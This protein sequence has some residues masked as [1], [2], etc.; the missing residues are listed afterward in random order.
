MVLII[1]VAGG[2]SSGK[3][4]FCERIKQELIGKKVIIVSQDDY[5]KEER[6][7]KPDSID[8]ELL[9]SVIKRLKGGDAVRIKGEQVSKPDVV[10]VEGIFTLKNIVTELFDLKIFLETDCETRMIRRM[11]REVMENKRET[12]QVLMEYE[13]FVKPAFEEWILPTRKFANIVIP[14]QDKNDTALKV[15]LAFIN[16]N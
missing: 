9:Y 6:D 2:S 4:T 1:G 5:Y 13:K 12:R 15:V 11:R 14:F 16:K 10:M 8:F 3:K 7:F